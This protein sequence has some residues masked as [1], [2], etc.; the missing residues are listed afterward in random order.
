MCSMQWLGRIEH[1]VNKAMHAVG[2]RPGGQSGGTGGVARVDGGGS[3]GL[4]GGG[5]EN[6]KAGSGGGGD[7][8]LGLMGGDGPSTHARL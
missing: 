2:S 1:A 8:G 6:M 7:D 4:G 5:E 3:T